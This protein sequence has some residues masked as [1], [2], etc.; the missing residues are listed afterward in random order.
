MPASS[1]FDSDS[2]GGFGV[3]EFNG[4]REKWMVENE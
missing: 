4:S 3:F 1:C 2:D